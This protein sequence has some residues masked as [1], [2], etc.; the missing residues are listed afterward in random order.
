[1][2]IS[3]RPR[4]AIVLIVLLLVEFMEEKFRRPALRVR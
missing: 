3:S 2:L 4:V 1:M